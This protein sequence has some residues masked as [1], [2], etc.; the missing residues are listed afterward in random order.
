VGEDKM[1]CSGD[2]PLLPKTEGT[3]IHAIVLAG[4]SEEGNVFRLFS[5]FPLRKGQKGAD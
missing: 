1:S 3:N 5:K 2:T 4:G